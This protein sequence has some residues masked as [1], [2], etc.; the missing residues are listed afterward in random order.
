MVLFLITAATEMEMAPLRQHLAHCQGV[1]F[2]VT[3]VGMVEAVLGL[4]RKLGQAGEKIHGVL[5]LGVAGAYVDT[6]VEVLDLCLAKREVIGDLGISNGEQVVPFTD[7]VIKS[8]SDFSLQ[9]PLRV[10]AASILTEKEIAHHTGVFVTVNA[11]SGSTSRGNFLRDQHLAICE[12][13]E[14][15]AIART[16]AA[17]GLD[18]LELRSVSNL[19][20]DR[21]PARWRLAEAISVC[22]DAAAQLIPSLVAARS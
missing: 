1:E 10:R 7:E 9:N 15:A 3:G 16:C 19:V 4:G 14:G 22:A 17:Y 2:L 11:V 6:G 8:P 12:N 21:D 13:M 20:E 18:C 5:N